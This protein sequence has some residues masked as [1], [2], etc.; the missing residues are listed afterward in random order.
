MSATRRRLVYR[1]TTP[2]GGV[3]IR[4]SCRLDAVSPLLLAGRC[5]AP[6]QAA[7][8][9]TTRQPFAQL[10]IL[11]A[12]RAAWSSSGYRGRDGVLTGVAAR[13]AST[14]SDSVAGR[15]S[16]SARLRSEPEWLYC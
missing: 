8:A 7:S 14:A 16:A 15:V 11:L 4:P 12:L 10:P 2:G 13:A 9:L 3:T 1:R 6:Q 5:V